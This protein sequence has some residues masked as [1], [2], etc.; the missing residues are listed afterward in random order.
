MRTSRNF[1]I[2]EPT[3]L[4]RKSNTLQHIVTHCNTHC[5]TLQHTLHDAATHTAPRCNTH[6][7]SLQHTL[8][9]AATHRCCLEDTRTWHSVAHCNTL[10]HTATHC[11]TLQHT[12]T[13]CNTLQHTGAA[14]RTRAHDET[15]RFSRKWCWLQNQGLQRGPVRDSLICVCVRVYIQGGED[16]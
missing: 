3:S 13:H 12:A 16:P 10:Q 9:L 11:N 6:W 8:H 14:C 15:S 2:L 1:L 7:P 4:S 5:T